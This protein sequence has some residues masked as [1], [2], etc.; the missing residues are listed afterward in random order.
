MKPSFLDSDQDGGKAM[1]EQI[2]NAP[3]AAQVI[4][5]SQPAVFGDNYDAALEFYCHNRDDVKTLIDDLEEI[6]HSKRISKDFYCQE[7][8]PIILWFSRPEKKNE[9][10]FV[11]TAQGIESIIHKL[12][13][14][15]QLRVYINKQFFKQSVANKNCIYDCMVSSKNLPNIEELANAMAY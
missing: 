1:E 6:F 8:N 13:G 15:V 11:R 3:T 10:S 14:D 2:K 4:A 9:K 7:D 5:S 12:E